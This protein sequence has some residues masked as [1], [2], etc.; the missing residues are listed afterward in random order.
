MQYEAWLSFNSNLKFRAPYA[1]DYFLAVIVYGFWDAL[2]TGLVLDKP[3]V[4]QAPLYF[5]I[6]PRGV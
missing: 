6:I 2:F 1:F 3:V 5:R 4:T